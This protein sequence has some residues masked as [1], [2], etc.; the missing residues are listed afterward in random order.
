MSC[1]S[2]I[3]PNPGILKD[4]RIL[5][6]DN[7]ADSRYL[8][9]VLFEKCGAQVTSLGSIAAA[10][11]CLESFTPDILVCEIRF[12]NEDILSLVQKI[13]TVALGQEQKIPILVVSA[14]CLA[15]FA[16]ELLTMVEDYMLKPIDIDYLVAEVWNLVHS[17]KPAQKVKIQDSIEKD[18]ARTKRHTTVRLSKLLN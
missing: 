11:L 12:F 2:Q 13:K 8:H 4:I 10:I 17:A 9:Q 7:N 15:S 18:R 5:V 14:Y 16:P 6:V 1:K 3:L